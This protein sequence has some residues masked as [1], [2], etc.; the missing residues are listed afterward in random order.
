MLEREPGPPQVCKDVGWYQG[1]MKVIA[2]DDERSAEVYRA[3]ISNIGKVY[4]GAKLEAV[5]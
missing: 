3:A 5:K 4:P 1:S 2:C